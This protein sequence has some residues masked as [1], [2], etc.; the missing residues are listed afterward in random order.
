MSDTLTETDDGTTT[1]TIAV[2]PKRPKNPP[3]DPL[4]LVPIPTTGDAAA[5]AL[6]ILATLNPS[7]AAELRARVGSIEGELADLVE[8]ARLT[9]GMPHA[10]FIDR[11]AR[12]FKLR[13]VL[14]ARLGLLDPSATTSRPSIEAQVYTHA[15]SIKR[16]ARGTE[17]R[18]EGAKR[19]ETLRTAR[20]AVAADIQLLADMFV[21]GGRLIVDR[22]NQQRGLA[23]NADEFL[24]RLERLLTKHRS[25]S[26]RIARLDPRGNAGRSQG[27]AAALESAGG[28]DAVHE[29]LMHS[30]AAP[31][32]ASVDA[33]TRA[34]SKLD[35]QLGRVDPESR[36]AGSLATS[37]EAL[38]ATLEGAKATAAIQR[39]AAARTLIEA[40]TTGKQDAVAALEGAVRPFHAGLA[41][42]LVLVRGN[43][44][45]LVAAVG[46]LIGA[47]KA[48]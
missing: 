12:G 11:S 38:A 10:D 8:Q 40:A 13:A 17:L 16:W 31:A 19:A 27:V 23:T 25:L 6:T 5:A 3:M 21:S 15:T 34:L 1:T 39:A 46:E 4:P 22:E 28:I 2:A 35:D 29:L 14:E 33:T 26:D 47:A 32:E 48:S 7:A 43:V 41:D 42:D 20:D 37:R 36:K 45:A 30:M 18:T 44:D 9:T 24:F